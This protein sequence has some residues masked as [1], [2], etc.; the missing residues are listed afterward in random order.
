M[1]PSGSKAKD[2]LVLLQAVTEL[3]NHGAERKIRV[4]SLRIL[5]TIDSGQTVIDTILPRGD[6]YKH[7]RR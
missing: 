5:F 1:K 6:V 4:G 7:S 3:V 2:Y